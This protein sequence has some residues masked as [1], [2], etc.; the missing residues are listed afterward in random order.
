MPWASQSIAWQAFEIELA[1]H[2]WI[3]SAR[4]RHI[5]RIEWHHMR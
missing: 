1:A 5:V 2:F 4:M 3:W